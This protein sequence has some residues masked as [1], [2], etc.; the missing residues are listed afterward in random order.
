MFGKQDG[1]APF[2]V[3]LGTGECIRAEPFNFLFGCGMYQ[4]RTAATS[5]N[6][7]NIENISY[8]CYML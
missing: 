8:M 4:S 7:Q 1:A 2:F 5:L 3:W 6:N